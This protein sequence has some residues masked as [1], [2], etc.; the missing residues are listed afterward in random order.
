M[1]HNVWIE[2][3][4]VVR[5]QLVL[6]VELSLNRHHEFMLSHGLAECQDVTDIGTGNGLFLSRIAAQHPSTWFHGIDNQ[7]QMVEEAKTHLPQNIDWLVADA[8]GHQTKQLLDTTD[9]IIMRYFLLHLSNT[10]SSLRQILGNVRS[11]T[12]LWIIDLDPDFCRCEPLDE[13]FHA[14]TELVRTFCKRNAVEIRLGTVSSSILKSCG[15][16]V[17]DIVV[18]PFNNREIDLRRFSEFLFREASLYHYS[19]Y[20]TLGEDELKPLRDFLR[21]RMT[22]NSHFVQ[23][24]MIMVSAVKT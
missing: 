20:G 15:F 22:R 6:Q 11:G 10:E 5:D 8:L 23:Y 19:L 12:R 2:M 4:T 7:P 17:E 3:E 9:G 21:G 18:E 14:F 1:A 13:A 24:G 16:H